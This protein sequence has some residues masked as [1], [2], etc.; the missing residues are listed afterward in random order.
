[1]LLLVLCWSFND[2]QAIEI[3]LSYQCISEFE[4]WLICWLLGNPLSARIFL[5]RCVLL[6]LTIDKC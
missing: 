1:M 2:V 4:V 6:A 5:G 3:R